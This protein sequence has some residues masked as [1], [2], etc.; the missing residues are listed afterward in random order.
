M[1]LNVPRNQEAYWG[2]GWGGGGGRGRLYTYHYTVT[3]TTRMTPALKKM[4]SD[5]DESHGSLFFYFCP[6]IPI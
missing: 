5:Y 4:G 6:D 3:F 1:V 2:W